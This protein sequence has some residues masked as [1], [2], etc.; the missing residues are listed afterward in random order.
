MAE[1]LKILDP[2]DVL[3]EHIRKRLR[4]T[5]TV[6]A[7]TVKGPG[8][9]TYVGQ[10]AAWD[11]LQDDAGGGGSELIPS[12]GSDAGLAYGRGMTLLEAKL[13]GYILGM[14]VDIA[15]HDH[16][17]AGGN[18]APEQRD[19]AVRMIKHNYCR[20]IAEALKGAVK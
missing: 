7:R 2:A 15:A 5:K 19:A 9:D 8:G 1:D 11:T 6:C 3:L 14:Q 18:M 4:V 16:A 10:A 12:A 20:L 17:M 13:A